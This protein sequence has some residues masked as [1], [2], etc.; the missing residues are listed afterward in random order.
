MFDG[1]QVYVIGDQQRVICP[2]HQNALLE[3]G[4]TADYPLF[5]KCSQCQN[6][7]QWTSEAERDQEIRELAARAST[8]R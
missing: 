3:K 2:N 4:A 5:W 7:A 1:L 6:S 8:R